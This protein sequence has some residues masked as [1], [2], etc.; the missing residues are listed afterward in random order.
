MKTFPSWVLSN[1]YTPPP[2]PAPIIAV[3]F[4]GVREGRGEAGRGRINIERG[5]LMEK[6]D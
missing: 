2:L 5:G 4:Q 3:M 6:M 1:N